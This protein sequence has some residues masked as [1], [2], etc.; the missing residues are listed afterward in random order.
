MSELCANSSS[1][2]A[3]LGL[4]QRRSRNQAKL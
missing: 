1:H 2:I 4:N 3:R